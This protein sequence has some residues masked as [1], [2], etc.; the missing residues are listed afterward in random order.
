MVDEIPGVK[1][2]CEFE[3]PGAE[4]FSECAFRDRLV[5]FLQ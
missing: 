4:D 2:V 3:A 5:L 1:L